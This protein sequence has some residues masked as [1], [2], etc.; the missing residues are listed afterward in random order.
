VVLL[1]RFPAQP[2]DRL[3]SLMPHTHAGGLSYLFEVGRSRS[4][5]GLQTQVVDDDDQ[6]LGEAHLGLEGV[7]RPRGLSPLEQTGRLG[8]CRPGSGAAPAPMSL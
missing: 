4:R 5:R 7:V 1:E 3:M 6:H 2:Y 8:S